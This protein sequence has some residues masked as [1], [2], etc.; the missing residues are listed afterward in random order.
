MDGWI[1]DAYA[2]AVRNTIVLWIKGQDVRKFEFTYT[3]HFY[4]HGSSTDLEVLKKELG[5]ALSISEAKVRAAPSMH[6]MKVLRISAPIGVFREAAERI[7][8][9][10]AHGRYL[11]FDVDMP[12]EHR[13]MLERGIFPLAHVSVNG[14]SIE[15]LDAQGEL[16]YDVPELTTVEMD[17]YVNGNEIE[18]QVDGET[19][20][21]GADALMQAMAA[22]RQRDPDVVI[23]RGG[24]R[25]MHTLFS[26]STKLKLPFLF[27]REEGLHTPYAS[28]SYSS[29]GRVV[30]RHSPAFLN[31]RVHIDADNSFMYSEAG[32]DGLFEVSRLSYFPPQQLSRVSPG[33]AI[34]SMEN[35]EAY[36]R[37]IAVP[38]KKN[39]PEAF[40]KAAALI[41]ADRGGLIY[42]PRV[43]FFTD[44]L[45]FDFSSMYPSIMHR[46][47]ISVDTLNCSCCSDGHTVPGLDYHFC[48]KRTGLVPS[49][50]SRLIDRRRRYRQRPGYE[51]RRTALK[52]V[53]VTSFGYTGYKN[54][55]FGSIECHEAINAYGREILL[56]AS[57]IAEE[58]KFSVLHGIVDSLWLQGEGDA[59]AYAL[60]VERRTGIP[61][62][63][64][65][66]Y[67]WIV[68][69]NN[70]GNAAGSLN[71]YYGLLEDGNWK[72]RG[73]ELRRSDTPEIVRYAQLL[74]LEHLRFSTTISDFMERAMEGLRHVKWLVSNMSLGSYP[75]EKMIITHRVSKGTGGYKG[76]NVQ[77]RLLSLLDVN[78]VRINAGEAIE[79]VLTEGEQREMPACML[80]GN[81]R[82]DARRYRRLIARAMET[83]LLPFGF[84][85]ERI[86]DIFRS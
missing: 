58:M 11:L 8:A 7:Y 23:T 62:E 53:L 73:I 44:V 80:K 51:M 4:V 57:R 47:N 36:V 41:E 81:E 49:V 27:G 28:R 9:I 15:C 16:D 35:A 22:V 85:E 77:H 48:S 26:M 25:F 10:G 34:S 39:R 61:F 6:E 2:D 78:G 12:F 68:F 69:L 82:Y 60:E 75:I 43:G 19:F 20:S 63:L 29:Y 17:A 37:G 50:V 52:W 42:N 59:E 55:R 83:M 5:D 40:K 76:N 31:G 84:T 30:Y 86:M 56:L 14:N 38:W 46:Y 71:R 54:A 79:Y 67:R 66:R 13:F 21:C 24:D 33:T 65:S 74:L 18:A 45:C 32:M 64:D 72:L 1:I 3:P 70:K